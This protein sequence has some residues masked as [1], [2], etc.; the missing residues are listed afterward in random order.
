M[1]CDQKAFHQNGTVGDVTIK[2][3]VRIET[4]DGIYGLTPCGTFTVYPAGYATSALSDD[5]KGWMY[6]VVG[7]SLPATLTGP[8]IVN[9]R[10]TFAF[11]Y[12]QN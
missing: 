7:G 11:I 6:G 2:D 4:V 9:D 3:G 10:G 12:D 5:V 8:L 1:T